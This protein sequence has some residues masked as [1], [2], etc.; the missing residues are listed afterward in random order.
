MSECEDVKMRSNDE[1]DDEG[2]GSVRVDTEWQQTLYTYFL[3][4]M[5]HCEKADS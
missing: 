1:I 4:I 3:H 5:H 2:E